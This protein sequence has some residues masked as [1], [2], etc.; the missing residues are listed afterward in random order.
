MDG[1]VISLGERSFKLYGGGRGG[2]G[3]DPHRFPP[4]YGNRSYF[5]N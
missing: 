3:A 4:F 1:L 2:A 5:H